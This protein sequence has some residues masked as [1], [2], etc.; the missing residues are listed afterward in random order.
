MLE[1]LDAQAGPI[2]VKSVTV[3]ENGALSKHAPQFPLNFDFEWR[4]SSFKGT[5]ES[6]ASGLTL[7][8]ATTLAEIPFTAEDAGRR[9]QL[10]AQIGDDSHHASGLMVRDGN[11]VVFSRGIPLSEEDGLTA[12]SLITDLAIMVLTAAPCLDAMAE[13]G[14]A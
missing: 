8:L 9:S 7:T 4:S 12:D 3:D 1:T 5:V 13:F 10:L 6:T 14:R 11:R 2:G